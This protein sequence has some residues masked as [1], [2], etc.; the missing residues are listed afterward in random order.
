MSAA[1][2]RTQVSAIRAVRTAAATSTAARIPSAESTRPDGARKN[3]R[4]PQ[5]NAYIRSFRSFSDGRRNRPQTGLCR[6]ALIGGN[7]AKCAQNERG[8]SCFYNAK[9]SAVKKAH[10]PPCIVGWKNGTVSAD[11]KAERRLRQH[12]S[13][14]GV[15]GQRLVSADIKAERRLRLGTIAAMF[16]CPSSVCQ[17]T[18]KPKGD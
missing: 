3:N 4:E 12:Y 16:P 9:P 8:A 18:S 10:F 14:F 7:R 1:R 11:I 17:P 15:G 2:G 5:A 6:Q 13:P